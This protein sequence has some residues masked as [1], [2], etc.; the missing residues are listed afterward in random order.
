MP[1]FTSRESPSERLLLE[2]VARALKHLLRARQRACARACDHAAESAQLVC[3]TQ[4]LNR[5]TGAL[6]N[7]DDDDARGDGGSSDDRGD[8]LPLFGGRYGDGGHD[9]AARR[10][11]L[12]GADGARRAYGDGAAEGA[13]VR[14]P[15]TATAAA[16]QQRGSFWGRGGE[17]ASAVV[18]RFGACALSVA[19]EE[20]LHRACVR[21]AFL[22]R[23]LR[24]LCAMC[25]VALTSACRAALLAAPT[26]VA[27][28]A[29]AAAVVGG[30]DRDAAAAAADAAADAL[31]VGFE[32]VEAGGMCCFLTRLS[33]GDV[34]GGRV[35]SAHVVAPPRPALM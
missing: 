33:S 27:P 16:R 2:V 10:R 31:L 12:G 30:D 17:V 26:V 19:E 5:V 24:M 29:N 32:F 18:A 1:R 34:E 8:A 21:G 3:V 22:A 11:V 23:L 25:G 15:G 13:A 14:A 9:G 7:D 20:D 35:T 28:R 4:F 6:D